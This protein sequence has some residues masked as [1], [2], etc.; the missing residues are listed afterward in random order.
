M[1]FKFQIST[2]ARVCM[3]LALLSGMLGTVPAS[4]QDISEPASVDLLSSAPASQEYLITGTNNPRAMFGYSVKSA[5]DVNG[6]GFDDAIIGAREYWEGELAEGAAFIYFGSS[7]GQFG[8]PAWLV[9]SNQQFASMGGS[10]DTAGDVNGDGYDD[11]LVGA[12]QY[13]IGE[14]GEGVVF[15][16]YGSPTGPST[17]PDWIGQVN[18]ADAK[19]GWSV[20]HAGDVNNDGY[21]DVVI[22]SRYYT[23]G[24]TDEGK[25]F[26]Y[27]GS[28]NGL[29]ST[30]AWSKEIDIQDAGFGYSVSAAGDANG[31]GYDDVLVTS[32]NYIYGTL[33][34]GKAYL[35]LGKY[36]G[37][38]TAPA[39]VGESGIPMDGYG[40]VG[41]NAGDVNGDGY[42][43]I[44]VGAPSGDNDAVNGK[45]YLYLG[46]AAGPSLQPDWVE[47]GE[48]DTLF[49]YSLDSA[50]DYN[51]DGYDDIVVGDQIYFV[52]PSIAGAIFLYLGGPSGPGATPYLSYT[53]GANNSAFATDVGGVGRFNGDLY[54]DFLVGAPMWTTAPYGGGRAVLFFGHET[55]ISSSI[56]VTNTNDSGSGSLRQ[57]ITD[58]CSGGTIHFAAS[59][60]GKT[61][62]LASNFPPITKVLTIDGGG[63]SITIDGAGGYRI[64]NVMS[65]GNL[66]I[67]D[68][69]IQ[70][71]HS[72][73]ECLNDTTFPCGGAVSS[74]GLLTVRDSTF[75]GN[76]SDLG[77]AIFINTGTANVS[78][79]TFLGNSAMTAGGGIFNWLGIL[80]VTNS[81]FSANSA[82]YGGGIYNDLNSLTLTN[83]TFSEN[84]AMQG[85]GL[86]N[87][88]ISLKFMNNILANSISGDDCYN[89]DGAGKISTN[90]SNLVETSAAA[91]NHC[92]TAALAS[93]PRL[94]PLGNY[95]GPTQTI[96][97]LWDSP[98]IDAGTDANCPL[99]DQRGVAR[100]QGSHCDLGAFEAGYGSIE[101]SIGTTKVGSYSLSAHEG[102]RKSYASVNNGPVKITN[103]E[104]VPIL[105]A[106]RVIYKVEDIATSYSE[107]MG[108]PNNQVD[109][110]YWL[111]WYNSKDLNTQLRIANVSTNEATVHVSIGGAP[112]TGSPFT[113]P[114]GASRRLSFSGIDKGPV[115][116][117]SNVNI[118]AAE[119]VIYRVNGVDTSYSEMMALPNSQLDTIYWLPWYNSKDLDT[120]LRIANVSAS[121]ATVHVSIGG[122][123]VIGS[124]FTIPA[125]VSK[126]LSFPNIDKGPVKIESNVDI[127]AAERVIYKIDDVA[128]SFTEMMALPNSRIDT[129]FGL[130]WYN[131]QSLNT[132]LRIANVSSSDATVH[133]SVG[134]TPVTGSPFSIPAGGSKRLSFPGIDKGPV[135]IESNADIIASERVIYTVNGKPTSFSE[136]MGLPNALLD[137]LY[138]FPW[139]NNK[140]LDTQLRFGLP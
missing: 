74:D 117:E 118:V 26:L 121:T 134:G 10:V 52:Y 127:V 64:F 124:P 137:S 3:M 24:Q 37:L 49:G 110:T 82:N 56:T 28:A 51:H 54:D 38:E 83:S 41:A 93:D 11:V 115:K 80:H 105:A 102:L 97:L 86:Y 5:G 112:I 30:P 73:A 1:F 78:N 32:Y 69:T 66:T 129:V 79:S 126:R 55:C 25:A 53:S 96:P 120:Q 22:G 106:E 135:Q 95:G 139:Y 34:G 114:V 81:T 123:P 133:I 46:S 85:G 128:T 19:F 122:A 108:L 72:S 45:A 76:S 20:S 90:I 138:W 140:D 59:V 58:I 50:G 47:D 31:D 125:G 63:Q 116:I 67:N 18:Q 68:L 17:T 61:I 2:I 15:A 12:Y 88:G 131:S 111:P 44:L 71:G 40:T 100:P 98:A 94:S 87:A 70:N 62:T 84:S 14:V 119:R 60:S 75:S 39:W 57:A 35:F 65:T 27:L 16:Y 7:A 92:G 36:G 8:T 132:Q 9:Q 136:M 130:P 13:T 21:D 29:A 77:G 113:I 89:E 101:V 42:S 6:D 99:T 4:A 109:T 23:N 43:D 91:P 48:N 104:Y 103:T 33:N 107:L